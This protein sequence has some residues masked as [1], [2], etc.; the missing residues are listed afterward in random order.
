MGHQVRKYWSEYE[1]WLELAVLYYATDGGLLPKGYHEAWSALAADHPTHATGL[2]NWL[3]DMRG[4][5][6]ISF[7]TYERMY[8]KVR[9]EVQASGYLLYLVPAPND[10]GAVMMRVRFCLQR[11]EEVA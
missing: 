6:V 3:L 9:A 11:A 10:A 8:R 4:L 7:R 1:A 5:G 2:C